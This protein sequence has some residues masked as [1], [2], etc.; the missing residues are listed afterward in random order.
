MAL[1]DWMKSK[2]RKYQWTREDR[3]LSIVIYGPKYR[4]VVILQSSYN[5][6]LNWREKDKKYFKTKS[7]ALKFAKSYMRK[8]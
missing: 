3:R 5:S 2:L 7:A 4:D 8:H 6:G 1:K